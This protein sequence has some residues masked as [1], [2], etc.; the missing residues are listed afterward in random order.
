M[1]YVDIEQRDG[2]RWLY[3]NSF[4]KVVAAGDAKTKDV[5]EAIGWALHDARFDRDTR[6][7][8]MTGRDDGEFYS[9]P[10]AAHYAEEGSRDRVNPMKR[11]G[12]GGPS[13]YPDAL[14]TLAHLEKP[15]VARVNGDVIG[16]GQSVLWGSDIIVAREDA[17]ISDVHLGQGEVIDSAGVARGFP[18][19][20][21]PGD[22]ALAFFPLYLPPTKLKE[23]MF[24]SRA[25]TATELARLNIVNYAVPLADLD[26]ILDGIVDGLL[27]RPPSVL[28]HTKRACN[29]HLINQANLAKD[30]AGAY[31][32]NDLWQHASDGTW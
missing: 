23:Y 9:V 31:E 7:I 6:I 21:T 4:A 25:W 17:V 30:L 27:A 29:K 16:F 3:L 32:V 22:G 24:L 14:E 19:G 5:H 15:V 20:I 18:A 28:A 10:P 12:F 8:V 26:T 2:V 13:H 11:G 1:D